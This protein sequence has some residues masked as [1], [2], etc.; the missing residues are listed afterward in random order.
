MNMLLR[1][2]F[3]VFKKK[4][5]ILFVDNENQISNAMK[6]IQKEVL[7]GVDTEFDWRNT[8][9]PVLSLLQISTAKSIFLIDCLKC[10]DLKFFKDVLED[11][12]KLIIFHSARSDTTVLSTNLGI[13]I[14]KVFDIQIAEKL[15]TSGSIKSY[16]SIVSKYFGKVLDKSETNSN[17]LRRP[18]KK[19]QI[20]YAAKDVEFLL[21]IYQLQ[22][23]I[24][25]KKNKLQD[26]F[27][28]SRKEAKLGNQDLKISRLKR[29]K[30]KFSQREKDIFLWREDMAK[31]E[32]I[33]TSFLFKDKYLRKLSMFKADEENLKSKIINIMGDT[34][35]SEKFISN[36]F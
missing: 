15:L 29:K 9:F 27:K 28:E 8:Y 13:R 26:V 17:W 34:K 25:Y 22:K 30:N 14:K 12:N 7:L 24:L 33:P 6:A 1:K 5:D 10:K 36:F 18:L 23:K 21:E 35:L 32:N 11:K 20:S 31:L 3:L 19:K 4:K 16:S 2:F